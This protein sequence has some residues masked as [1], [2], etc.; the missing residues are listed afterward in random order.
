MVLF[1]P[2]KKG[3]VPRLYRTVLHEGGKYC[4]LASPA[5]SSLEMAEKSRVILIAVD[6]SEF[7]KD[8]VTCKY[9]WIWYLEVLSGRDTD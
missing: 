2:I 5:E 3:V 9:N 8:A 1:T 7:S 4:I 6:G